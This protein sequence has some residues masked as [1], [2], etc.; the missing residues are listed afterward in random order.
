MWT[1][2]SGSAILPPAQAP[3]SAYCNKMC[4][5]GIAMVHPVGDLLAEWS[6]LG[7]PTRTGKPWS[8]QEKWEA[9]AWGPHQSSLSPKALAHITEESIEKVQAGQAKLVMWDDRNDDPPAQ[10]KI[11]PIVVIPHK[12][13]ALHSNL[14]LSFCL[15]LKHISFLNSVNNPTVKL[16]PQG[17]LDQLGHALSQ[18]I[19]AFAESHDKAKIV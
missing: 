14:D 12:S 6:Q 19:H 4:P 5:A 15:Q 3:P 18:I 11:S 17:A 1:R 7:C 16:A 2:Y 8:K 10:L 13:K 9:V